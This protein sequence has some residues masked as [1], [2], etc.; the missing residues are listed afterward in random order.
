MNKW[1]LLLDS[2]GPT[3][4]GAVPDAAALTVI[5]EVCQT[6]LNSDYQAECG[7]EI[8]SVRYSDGTD[9]QADEKRYIFTAT[10]PDAPGASAY[11]VP[12]AAYC[13]VSTCADLYGPQGVSVDASH[14]VLEDAGNPG[15]NMAVDDGKGQEHERERCDAVETQTYPITHPTAGAVHVSNFLLDS[16]QVQGGV[17]PYSFMAKAGLPGAVDPPGP[18]QTAVSP[19]NGNY[20]LV[21]PSNASQMN[22]VFGFA[23]EELTTTQNLGKRLLGKP[24][25]PEKAL[26]WSSRPARI[27][28]ARNA[29][30]LASL[31]PPQ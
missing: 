1:V 7:G 14:E 12:G 22:P 25:R 6:Q 5:A 27:V 29:R 18:F 13:A 24:R 26:H 16:W 4:S 21:F 28:R 11:H 9:I 3:S 20:Q 8:A 15:C 19:G 23:K 31:R 10:L 30:I 17:G 2:P